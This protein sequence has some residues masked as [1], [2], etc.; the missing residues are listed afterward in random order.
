[1]HEKLVTLDD[2][3]INF[4]EAQETQ[5]QSHIKLLHWHIAERLVIEGGINPDDIVPHPP[6]RVETAGSGRNKRFRLIHD[7]DSAVAGELTI[8]GGL[9]T[10]DVDIVVSR[11]GIGPCIAISV[12]GTLN[13][14]RNLTNRMEEAAG[15]CTNIH[16]SYPNLVYGF[17]HVIR[18]NCEGDV[19]KRNDIAIESNGTVVD[20]I[21]RYHDAISRLAG[22]RDVRNDVSRYE[23]VCLALVDTKPES[24]GTV[25]TSFPTSQSPIRFERFFETI[26]Q[27]YDLRYVYTAP[28]LRGATTR[29]VWAAD[30]PALA[31]EGAASFASRMDEG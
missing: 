9:K 11:R 18:A 16:I 3:L 19:E 20:G 13:A 12:K 5:S 15:D 10:K 17:F 1:M 7:P 22:R 14:F 6:L 26:Y 24:R 27:S 8:L 23:A 28:A 4:I 2:A 25:V 31:T 30:S 21:I 29:I